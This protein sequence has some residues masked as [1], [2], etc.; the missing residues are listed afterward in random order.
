MTKLLYHDRYRIPSARLP[1]HDYSHP[2]WYFIT[3]CTNIRYPWFG[4]IKNGIMC[5]NDAGTIV[6][7]ELHQTELLRTNVIVDT[8]VVMPDHIHAIVRIITHDDDIRRSVETHSY[9]SLHR[10][11]FGPQQRN[12]ASI[13]RGFKGA[14]TKRIRTI[15]HTQFQ[16]QPRYYDR[17]I[18]SHRE[19]HNVRKYII[20]NPR[21]YE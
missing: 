12:L 9:A 8:W 7:Q 3:I 16:W 19:L 6:I 15:G 13:V 21:K 5:V 18:R 10:N 1:H 20:K 14:T 2:G 4:Y 11:V 17:I